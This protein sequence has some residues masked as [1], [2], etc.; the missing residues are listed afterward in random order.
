MEET[1]QQV[2]HDQSP[3]DEEVDAAGLNKKT[4]VCKLCQCKILG[5]G[6]GVLIEKQVSQT[7]LIFTFQDSTPQSETNRGKSYRNSKVFLACKE[8]ARF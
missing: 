3:T 8:H 1:V 2:Q 4:L 6:M 7:P 5:S